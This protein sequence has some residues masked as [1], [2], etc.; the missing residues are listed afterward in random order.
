[1]ALLRPNFGGNF[2]RGSD[3]AATHMRLILKGMGYCFIVFVLTTIS[4]DSWLTSETVA[5]TDWAWLWS[6]F[7]A[8]RFCSFDQDIT[9]KVRFTVPTTEGPM[10][11]T[12]AELGTPPHRLSKTM[13]AAST[14]QS[15]K[16]SWS[17][18]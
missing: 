17:V 15:L 1:M 7:W 12:A 13:S 18:R 14:T 4:V 8:K 5:K 11:M 3:T 6:V 10:D 2:T 16:P 9:C